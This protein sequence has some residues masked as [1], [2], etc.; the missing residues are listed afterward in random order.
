MAALKYPVLMVHGMGFR[1]RKHLG[2]WGR[3]PAALE[4]EGC[5]IYFGGQDSC[6]S[7]E[8]NAKHLAERIES[9]VKERG[10]EKFNVIAHSK[11]GLDIRY[12]MSTLGMGKYIASVSTVNTPHNGS[13]TVDKIKYFPDRMVRFACNC[14][15]LC[16]KI[17]GDGDPN[18]YDAVMG[19]KTSDAERFNREN[20]DV[21]GV[22]YQSFA[23]TFKS[24]FSDI[25]MWFPHFVVKL[26][27]GENDGLL[28]PRAVKWGDFR[29]VFTGATNRG[30]SHCDE[31]DLRRRPFTK[32]NVDGI[33]DIVD[34]YVD[35]VRELASKGF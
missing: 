28:T 25:L 10:I 20:P 30:I 23:F 11:G 13:L 7:V 33:T 32:K 15:D 27:E 31:V 2:Y 21:E 24:A 35:M 9:L 14:C 22:Y 1:D 3:I 18:V 16:F 4:K 29:G 12:A 5:T 17:L 8:T 19:F 34:F 6:G 26:I